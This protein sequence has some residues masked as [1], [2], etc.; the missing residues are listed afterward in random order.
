MA[1]REKTVGGDDMSKECFR[2]LGAP[3]FVMSDANDREASHS[4]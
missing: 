2:V 3:I 1:V 4:G